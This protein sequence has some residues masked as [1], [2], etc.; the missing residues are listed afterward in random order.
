MAEVREKIGREV[1]RSGVA[2]P[3]LIYQTAFSREG[4]IWITIPPSQIGATLAC[5]IQLFNLHIVDRAHF[6]NT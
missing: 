3:L 4:E 1:G 6:R 5:P 2:A